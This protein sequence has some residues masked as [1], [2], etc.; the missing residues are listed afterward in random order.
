M[1]KDAARL[2]FAQDDGI[3][4]REFSASPPLRMAA[5]F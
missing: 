4:K 3:F 5:F 1:E 2:A